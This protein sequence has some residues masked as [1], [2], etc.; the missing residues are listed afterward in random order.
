MYGNYYHGGYMPQT[1]TP[2]PDMLTQL[3]QSQT[4]P[5]GG[6]VW[7]QG[8]AAAKS[9]AVPF[10]GSAPLFDTEGDVFYIKTVDASGMPLPLR[11]FKYTEMTPQSVPTASQGAETV[12]LSKYLTREE[13]NEILLELGVVMPSE[14]GDKKNAE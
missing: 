10:G 12:D 1:P 4:P 14:K 8:E 3:R 2:M 9:Y 11:V 5:A 7:V 6:I 13:L